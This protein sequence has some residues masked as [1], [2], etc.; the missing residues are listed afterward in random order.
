M[1][2]KILILGGTGFI[3]YHLAK[4]SLRKGFEVTSISKNKPIKERYIKKVNYIILDISNKYSV[5]KIINK[6]FNY[7]FNLAGYVDHSNKSETYKSHYLGCKY[8]ANFFVKKNIE[9][10]I[11]LGS[12]MEYGQI[13]SPQKEISK[14]NPQSIYAKSKLLSTKY[15]LNLYQKKNFPVT[16]LRLYQVYGPRQ[17][18]NRFLPIIISSC[19]SNKTFACSHGRQFRDFLYIDDLVDVIFLLLKKKESIGEIINIGYGK[20]VQIKKIIKRII[21]YYKSGKPLFNKIK[22][23]K[24]EQIKIYPSLS[25]VRKILNWKA[26]IKFSEGLRKTISY[27]NEN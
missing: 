15:L 21:N 8:I 16:I 10:F 3:G 27:Y 14:C 13:K 7:V 18:L 20:V 19:K 5:K 24:E 6:R 11:Q 9:R 2:K 17:D 12:C 4:E 22:L 1:K 23:R 25:K 26:R